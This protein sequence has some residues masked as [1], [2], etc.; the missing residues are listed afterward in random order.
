M[1]LLPAEVT[2]G[3][4]GSG[5]AMAALAPHLPCCAQMAPRCRLGLEPTLKPLSSL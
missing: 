1:P 3:A 2:R 4:R 5:Q